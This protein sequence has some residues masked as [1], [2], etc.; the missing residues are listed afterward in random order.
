MKVIKS[1]I[2]Y[3]PII[4][5]T[6]NRIRHLKKTINSLKKN[7]ISTHSDLIIFSDGAAS[8]NQR[9]SIKEVR[10]YIKKI[11]GF[12]SLKIYHRNKNYGLS[13]NIISGISK[14]FKTYHSA[15]ILEDDLL[16]NKFFLNYM[17]D[18]L[19]KYK[20]TNHV[21][22]IHGYIYPIQFKKNIPE[23]FFLKGAD[24]WGWATWKRAWKNFDRNGKRLINKIDQKNLNKE[25][26][27]NNSYD[28]YQ[29][30]KKQ[31]LRLN[32]SWAIRW[33]A[34]AFLKNMITLYPTKT[35]VKN[36]GADGSGTHGKSNKKLNF[37]NFSQRKYKSI[38]K[39]KI[40]LNENTHAKKYIENY[41]KKNSESFIKKKIKNIYFMKII[42][43]ILPRNLIN[44]LKSFM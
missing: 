37:N 2:K 31:I 44:L 21:A 7:K 9:E 41:F 20:N 28:Y 34:S 18:G 15:I 17:N 39:M 43:K 11:N 5:F 35:F 40:S 24:C 10:N 19:L 29:M 30:L 3:A 38:K 13:E 33:Y 22:S 27:F 12:K 8:D 42:Y 25:F 36:I 32:N 4:I 1:S 23:Y 26:N 6:F 14:V 16:L